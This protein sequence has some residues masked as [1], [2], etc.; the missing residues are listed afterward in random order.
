[1]SNEELVKLIQDNIETAKHM[2]QLYMNNLPI[3]RKIAGK[4]TSYA[5][6]EDL[7]QEGYFGLHEAVQ[8][9]ESDKEIKF[10]TYAVYWIRQAMQRYIENFGHIIRIPG[11]LV[12]DIMKYKKFLKLYREEYN[13]S[14]NGSELCRYLKCTP[15]K[16]DHLRKACQQ[17]NIKSLDAELTNDKGECSTL[18]ENCAGNEDV[19]NY[20]IE[21]EMNTRIRNN[22]WQIV[23]DSLTEQENEVITE[24]YQNSK[25][26]QEIADIVGSGVS[27]VRSIE[28]KAMRKLRMPRIK[29]TLEERF[30]IAMTKAYKSS[31]ISDNICYSST[32]RAVFKD[33]RIKI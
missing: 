3:I 17:Y 30:D 23:Q 25:T 33:M 5:E 32:E 20:V 21:H 14:P 2:E 6:L 15:K 18:G 16:L 9:Y 19:E 27:S 12:A 10:I 13:S 11:H 29:R 22:L 26:R 31:I 8:H 24:K 7:L 1:M 4:Y 28:E